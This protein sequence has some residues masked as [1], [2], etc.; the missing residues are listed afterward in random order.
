MC[1]KI[2]PF[3]FYNETILQESLQDWADMLDVFTHISGEDDDIIQK[4]K[5]KTVEHVLKDIIIKAWR[6]VEAFMSP[7]GITKYSKVHSG[8]LKAVFH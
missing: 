2:T 4:Q 3:C 1:M 5:D 8:I 7:N 6:T